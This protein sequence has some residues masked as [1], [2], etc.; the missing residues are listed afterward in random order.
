M[1][2]KTPELP[3]VQIRRLRHG[4]TKSGKP[5]KRQ[6]YN[7]RLRIIPIMITISGISAIMS[8]A[9]FISLLLLKSA[10]ANLCG[11]YSNKL[12]RQHHNVT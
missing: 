4:T 1:P 9:S 7:Y 10:L 11:N 12:V 3:D 5:W 2:R 8:I 6:L